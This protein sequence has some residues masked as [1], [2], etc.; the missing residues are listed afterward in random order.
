MDDEDERIEQATELENE[1]IG[2]MATLV[3]EHGYGEVD[4][5]PLVQAAIANA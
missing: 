5:L 2:S 4:L 1:A 3:A